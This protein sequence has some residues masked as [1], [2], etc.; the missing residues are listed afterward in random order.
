MIDQLD[1]VALATV[2]PLQVAALV[3]H[4]AWTAKHL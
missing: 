1:L 4:Y 3:I 2:R